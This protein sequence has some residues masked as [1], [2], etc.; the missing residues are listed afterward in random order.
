[1][2]RKNQAQVGTETRSLHLFLPPKVGVDR[3]RVNITDG[4]P[5]VRQKEALVYFL[6]C[7]GTALIACVM[8]GLSLTFGCSERW[9]DMSGHEYVLMMVSWVCL[10]LPLERRGTHAA[11]ALARLSLLLSTTVNASGS[12][13]CC[14]TRLM[15]W[16]SICR[17]CS[18][19]SEL[20]LSLSLAIRINHPSRGVKNRRP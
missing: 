9:N 6:F 16:L 20:S 14:K 18:R 5:P 19:P 12:I 4:S 8:G 13:R 1:M 2:T 11:G 10:L 15:A 17:G 7:L 3:L